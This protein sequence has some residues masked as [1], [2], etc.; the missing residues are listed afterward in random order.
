MIVRAVESADLAG[1]RAI[2][3]ATGQSDRDSG[4]DA[5]YVALLRSTGT[6]LAAVDGD[7]VLGWA[8]T[9]PTSSGTL[10]TD[11]F[12]DPAM[13]ARGVATALL[14]R[15]WP[16]AAPRRYTFSSK[17]P[18]AL[19]LYARAG[20]VPSWPLLYVSGPTSRLPRGALRVEWVSAAKAAAAEAAL[21]GGEPRPGVFAY[22]GEAFVVRNRS[23]VIAVGAA[24]PGLPTVLAHLS[25]PDPGSAAGAL[26]A[27]VAALRADQV[28]CC[29]PG[30]H[31]ALQRLLAAG[32]RVDDFDVLMRTLDVEPPLGAVYSPGLG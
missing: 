32:F 26:F 3:H 13:H 15:L 12:V 27:A 8:A 14:G 4:A 23:R 1:I 25:C 30:P 24:Q 6:A 20:L 2:T 31:P 9:L 22:W 28:A 17:H 29:L 18:A 19:P 16:P 21:T 7:R 10:L 11:L 5:A